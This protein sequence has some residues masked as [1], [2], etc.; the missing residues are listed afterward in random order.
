MREVDTESPVVWPAWCYSGKKYN[1]LLTY[2]PT[3]Y[4]EFFW[5]EYVEQRREDWTKVTPGNRIIQQK[6]MC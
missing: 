6:C 2:L 1:F 5:S 4:L 3:F